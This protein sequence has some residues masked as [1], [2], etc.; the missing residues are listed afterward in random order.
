MKDNGA[1][2]HATSHWDVFNSYKSA[3]FE[4]AKMR[5]KGLA[6]VIGIRAVWLDTNNGTRLVLNNIKHIPDIQLNLIFTS[7]LDD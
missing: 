7:K 3:N 2:I 5:N 4:F 6:N 1:S